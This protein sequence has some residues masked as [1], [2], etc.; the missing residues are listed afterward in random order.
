MLKIPGFHNTGGYVGL[1]GE[2]M[3]LIH[4]HRAIL[5]EALVRPSSISTHVLEN[6]TKNRVKINRIL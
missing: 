6:L 2:E 3:R 1:K 4:N 5:K